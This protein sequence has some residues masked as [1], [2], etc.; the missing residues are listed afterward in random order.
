MALSQIGPESDTILE[1]RAFWSDIRS[2][3]LDSIQTVRGRVVERG[4]LHPRK[5]VKNSPCNRQG[6]TASPKAALLSLEIYH[7][8]AFVLD[9]TGA[10]PGGCN[11]LISTV[12][13]G[14]KNGA[15]GHEGSPGT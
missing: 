9:I 7:V 2:G 12:L 15:K 13:P 14:S 11:G 8:G 6:Q 3:P 5:K 10:T 1:K 4:H